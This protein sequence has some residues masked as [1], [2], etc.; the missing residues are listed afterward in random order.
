V[1]F[2]ILNSC[3]SNVKQVATL[4]K[5]SDFIFVKKYIFDMKIDNGKRKKEKITFTMINSNVQILG[6]MIFIE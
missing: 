4:Y 6:N 5:C 3:A 1:D 2:S